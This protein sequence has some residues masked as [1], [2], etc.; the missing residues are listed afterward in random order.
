VRQRFALQFQWRRKI[1]PFG[2]LCRAQQAFR[3]EAVSVCAL[4]IGLVGTKHG[5]RLF[6]V[7]DDVFLALPDFPDT[8]GE[9]FF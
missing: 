6:P 7:Q 3:D 9:L 1:F 8:T 4:W 2:L 5:H